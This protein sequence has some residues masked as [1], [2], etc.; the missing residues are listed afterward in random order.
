MGS[1]GCLLSDASRLYVPSPR[2]R[3]SVLV[4]YA[5]ASDSLAAQ[6]EEAAGLAAAGHRPGD[7][8]TQATVARAGGVVR[9][10]D[11]AAEP[12]SS[13]YRVL[14]HLGEDG[15]DEPMGGIPCRNIITVKRIDFQYGRLRFHSCGWEKVLLQLFVEPL[16]IGTAVRKTVGSDKID[17]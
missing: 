8:T 7:G 11:Q 16:S 2:S 1:S 12:R 4:F 13:G 15:I 9:R 14:E 17:T 10:T 3:R 5:S 6:R